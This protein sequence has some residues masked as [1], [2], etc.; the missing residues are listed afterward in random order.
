VVNELKEADYIS[1][2]D[3]LERDFARRDPLGFMRRFKKRVI[4]DEVQYVPEII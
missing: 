2:D 4:I 1:F 3:P